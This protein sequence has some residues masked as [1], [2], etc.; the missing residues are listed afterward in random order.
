MKL[1]FNY[2]PHHFNNN[3]II[4]IMKNINTLIRILV[5]TLFLGQSLQAQTCIDHEGNYNFNNWKPFNATVAKVTDVPH[6]NYLQL[7]DEEN[8]SFAINYIDFSR[9]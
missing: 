1:H 2:L 9:N 8:G 4:I 6:K 5:I 3:Y 7:T